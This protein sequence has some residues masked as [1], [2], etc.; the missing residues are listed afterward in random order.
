MLFRSGI[1]APART[2]RPVVDTLYNA[3][4]QVLRDPAILAG[5]ARS[6]TEPALAGP[7][8]FAAFVK[9]E[10]ERYRVVIERSGAKAE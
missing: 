10:I 6:G 8:E 1:H 7:D 2:P 4:A 3:F 5:M 9:S